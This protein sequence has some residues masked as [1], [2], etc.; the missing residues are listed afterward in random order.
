M[1]SPRY[2]LNTNRSHLSELVLSATIM[3]IS[4]T[5]FADE[6]NL[7]YV[8]SVHKWGAW[9][10]D[11]EPAAGGLT[12][13]G[14][15]A[16]NARESKVTPRTN[17]FAALAPPGK[18]AIPAVPAIPATPTTPAVPAVPATPAITPISPNV[19]IPVGGPG[20]PGGGPGA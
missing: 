10:L 15:R 13:P 4:T 17:S 12:Q 2:K 9:G 16:L 18:G 11:I 20:I 5:V 8:D 1:K 14:T 3:F 7:A 6:A 19:P